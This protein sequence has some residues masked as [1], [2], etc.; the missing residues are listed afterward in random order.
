MYPLESIVVLSA[1]IVLLGNGAFGEV[2]ARGGRICIELIFIILISTT[3][4]R[5][6]GLRNQFP[7][8]LVICVG[9][10]RTTPIPYS[11]MSKPLAAKAHLNFSLRFLRQGLSSSHIEHDSTRYKL[12]E[13][14]GLELARKI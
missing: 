12:Q 11:I 9:L 7:N 4:P 1:S 6:M 8:I 10:N 3:S 14:Q 13:A 2:E 5:G